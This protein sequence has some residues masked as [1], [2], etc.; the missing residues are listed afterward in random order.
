MVLF[1]G[2][3][4]GDIVGLVVAEFE[5]ALVVQIGLE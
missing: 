4:V 1:L 5:V 3:G 2:E